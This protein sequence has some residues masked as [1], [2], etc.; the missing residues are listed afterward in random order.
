MQEKIVKLL[1]MCTFV[2]ITPYAEDK[3]HMFEIQFIDY[4]KTFES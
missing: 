3:V 2:R 4:G 1:Y